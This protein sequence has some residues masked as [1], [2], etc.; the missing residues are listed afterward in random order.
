[1]G[2]TDVFYFEGLDDILIAMMTKKDTVSTAPQY[3]EIIRLPIATK[4]KVKGNG[5][6]LEKWA[7]SKMFRRVSRETKHE[8][9]LD[10]VG[11]PIELMDQ[12]KGLIAKNGVTFGKNNARELPY[13]A[14]GFIGNVEGGG[15][16]AVWYPKTQLSIV[17]DEEYATAEEETKIDDVT[18]NL[19][20]TGLLNNGVMYSSF[21]SNR[22][23]ALGVS[24]DKFISEP[25]FDETQWAEI[26]AAQSGG[27]GGGE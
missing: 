5:S 17:V 23:S 13:F 7:S 3:G 16:K 19:V 2:T 4:L 22:D 24:V 15:K 1:M 21:D 27:T 11:I 20:A 26:V 18:A 10:H 8:L 25:I 6:E 9:G 12:I 14:F